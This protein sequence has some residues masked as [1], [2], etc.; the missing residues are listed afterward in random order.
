MAKRSRRRRATRYSAR[1]RSAR[2]GY[3]RR[4]RVS[5]FARRGGASG[6]LRIVLEQPGTALGQP[7]LVRDP[8]SGEVQF[9]K[10][11]PSGPRTARF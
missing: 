5:S 6:T 4:R 11:A 2:S 1:S 8:S 7:M 10:Q 3:R 9:V